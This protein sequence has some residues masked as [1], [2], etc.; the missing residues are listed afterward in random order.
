MSV[1]LDVDGLLYHNIPEKDVNKAD[2][3]NRMFSETQK[4][5][6]CCDNIIR[7]NTKKTKYADNDVHTNINPKLQNM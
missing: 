5:R 2:L 1:K 3:L 6:K 7:K 4:N